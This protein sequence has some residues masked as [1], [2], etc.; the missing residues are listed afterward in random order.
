MCHPTLSFPHLDL[1]LSFWDLNFFFTPSK[2][3][4]QL[5]GYFSMFKGGEFTII[6]FVLRPAQDL[7][8]VSEW[9]LS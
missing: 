1:V 7:M 5:R 2:F 6:C 8:G 4:L 3:F 9:L